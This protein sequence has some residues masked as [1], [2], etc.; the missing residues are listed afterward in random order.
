[1]ARKTQS[2]PECAP[3]SPPRPRASWPR[4]ASTT[5]RSPSARRRGSS[6]RRT[7][8]IPAQR[9]NRGRAARL[10]RPLSGRRSPAAHRG[11]AAHRARR[12][13]SARALQPVPHRPGAQRHRRP[14]CAR[15]SCSCSRTARRTSR[16]FCSIANIPFT[17]HERRRYAGDRAH[18]VSLISLSWQDAPLRLRRL[19]SAG[20]ARGAEDL[21]RPDGSI[22]GPV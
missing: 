7:P 4:T 18:A 10:P 14:V 5:S 8:N 15:S 20:R 3:G 21:C 16:S 2:Q 11:A 13:A 6:A 19:R 22:D 17:T 9:R 1:M 12:Y